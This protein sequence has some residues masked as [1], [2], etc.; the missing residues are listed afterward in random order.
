MKRGLLFLPVVDT[1]KI[2]TAEELSR[3]SE[4]KPKVNEMLHEAVK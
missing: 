4:L 3:V 2:E 1:V